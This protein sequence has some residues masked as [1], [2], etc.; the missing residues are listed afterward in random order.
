MKTSVL[1]E[2]RELKIFSMKQSGI[3][4]NSVEWN[5]SHHYPLSTCEPD[6]RIFSFRYK[7]FFNNAFPVFSLYL[8]V[9]SS[10]RYVKNISN[11]CVRSKSDCEWLPSWVFSKNQA[12]SCRRNSISNQFHKLSFCCLLNWSIWDQ[13]AFMRSGLKLCTKDLHFPA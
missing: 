1:A 13:S 11:E 3:T 6:R 9:N 10:F 12:G 8:A 7:Y 4:K 2:V 5:Q